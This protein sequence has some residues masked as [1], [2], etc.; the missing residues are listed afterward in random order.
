MAVARRATSA[1]SAP[2]HTTSAAENAIV[3]GS[4][5][6][7]VQAV[8]TR[9]HCAMKKSTGT[10]GVLNSVANRAASAGALRSAA[11]DHDRHG[12]LHRLRQRGDPVTG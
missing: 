11:T 4:R 12:C 10:N 3:D 8:R 7:D 2:T 5:S 9:S 6:I 1:S